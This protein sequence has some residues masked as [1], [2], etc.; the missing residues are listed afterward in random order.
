[1]MLESEMMQA[2]QRPLHRP[3]QQPKVTQQLQEPPSAKP[4]RKVQTRQRKPDAPKSKPS[5]EGVQHFEVMLMGPN[6]I[7]AAWSP[8]PKE[9][10]D[11]Y[12]ITYWK[13]TQK[14]K[15]IEMPPQAIEILLE[16]L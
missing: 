8:L 15:V 10:I 9:S 6:S 4:E 16:N 11:G 5:L 2:R 12:K 7:S 3:A 1:M 14:K 13:E